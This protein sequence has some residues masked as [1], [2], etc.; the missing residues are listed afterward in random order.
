MIFFFQNIS[1]DVFECICGVFVEQL[2]HI[3]TGLGP[4][5]N[6]KMSDV[7]DLV[8]YI[9]TTVKYITFYIHHDF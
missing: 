1:G 2:S 8:M 3:T 4:R 5:K 7:V 9:Q 6:R